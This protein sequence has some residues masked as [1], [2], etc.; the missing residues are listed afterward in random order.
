[1]Q[2]DGNLV[3]Y[4]SQAW[5]STGTQSPS[6]LQDQNYIVLQGDG[7]LVEYAFSGGVVFSHNS[8]DGLPSNSNDA[9]DEDLVM[10]GDGNLVMYRSNGS[11][12]F[13]TTNES[14]RKEAIQQ[15][16]GNCINPNGYPLTSETTVMELNA[17]RPGGDYKFIA[18]SDRV[19]CANACA[20][21]RANDCLAYSWVPAGAAGNSGPICAMKNTVP[22]KVQ[23]GRG[24]VTGYI[25]GR[26]P[27]APPPR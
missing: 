7:N 11:V 18:S 12:A 14:W 27:P 15:S 8:G 17:D 23:D 5:W 2:H 20:Q 9:Q 19:A 25:R 26:Q 10:Q 16:F 3:L 6:G 1:M 22:A 24:V 13:A 21:D 4:G